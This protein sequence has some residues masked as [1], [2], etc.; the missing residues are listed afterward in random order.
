MIRA[1][2]HE[3][4]MLL[5]KIVA[6][7]SGCNSRPSGAVIVKNKRILATGYNGPMPGAWHCTDRGPGYCFRREK[8]IPD[9]DKYN[10][11][12]ATHAEANAIAQAARFGISVEGA[13]LYC[14]LAPCYV[15]LKLIAS[16]GIKKVYYEHDYGS[17]DFERDQFWKEAIKEAGLEK[18]E[19]ITVSQEVMEQLQ[20]ILPYPTSKRRLAPTEFLDEF[21]DGKKYGVPSIEVLFNKLNYLTR[22]ALKDITFVIE[23]TTVTEEPEGISFYLS[24]KMVELSEL[25]NTVKKQINADQ[26]FY[27]L[28]KHNAIEAK[29]EILR[30]AENIRLKAFLNE[31]PLESFKR[32]AESLD[33]ILYQVSNSLSLPTRL[34]LSVNLL[35]I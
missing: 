10:F 27:F 28:A 33:Y 29:I 6:L 2:W 24:G 9:I 22:Q 8:G 19:Q 20:E 1:P 14:T 7:R 3:Y 4:F 23:K 18:F 15:C 16:A 25:I 31:C 34:E 32:I 26:N 30:E 5:A 17:R 11:C 35:R 13:S 21:E 12:R